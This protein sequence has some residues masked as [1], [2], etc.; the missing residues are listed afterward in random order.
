[1]FICAV[2]ERKHIGVLAVQRE[3]RPAPREQDPRRETFNLRHV[4][5]S[6]RLTQFITCWLVNVVDRFKI[7]QAWLTSQYMEVQAT[8]GWL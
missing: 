4:S 1:M 6:M 5:Q 2:P 8:N 7:R 3:A